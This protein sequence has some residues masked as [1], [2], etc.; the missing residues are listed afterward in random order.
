MTRRPGRRPVTAPRP[1]AG[2]TLVEVIVAMFIM[3]G[4]I[5]VLGAFSATF[6]RAN[7]QAHFV[8]T[9]NEIAAARLDEART[10]TSYDA[11]EDLEDSSS[12]TTEG[13]AFT[14]RTMVKRIGGAPGTAAD[15]MDYKLL[16]VTV[17]H[18]AMRKIVS[19]TTAIAAY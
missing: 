4:V 15:T 6:A 19:K 10:Q 5:L 8:I 17:T 18:P 1:R 12:V 3:S 14:R 16:T 9:A 7:A 13:T 11:V 2:M